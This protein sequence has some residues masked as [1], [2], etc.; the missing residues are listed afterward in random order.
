MKKA[1][2][3]LWPGEGHTQLESTAATPRRRAPQPR[4]LGR[5]ELSWWDGRNRFSG[6]RS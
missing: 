3:P 2:V 5:R 1:V 6:P 4:A